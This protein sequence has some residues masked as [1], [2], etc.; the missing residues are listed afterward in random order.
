[1]GVV[2]RL[3]AAVSLL[4]IGGAITTELLLILAA[5]WLWTHRVKPW[6]R[7]LAWRHRMEWQ[8]WSDGVQARQDARL[9]VYEDEAPVWHLERVDD[10]EEHAN[11]ALNVVRPYAADPVGVDRFSLRELEDMRQWEWEATQP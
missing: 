10:F 11:Q 9:D 6:M 3:D 2:S 1:M 5:A 4:L 7:A 8:A